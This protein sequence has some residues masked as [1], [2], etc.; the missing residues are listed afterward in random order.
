MIQRLLGRRRLLDLI[1]LLSAG[2]RVLC[3]PHVTLFE[4]GA[5]AG[6]GTAYGRHRPWP[7]PG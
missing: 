2:T 1:W 4:I 5:D 3:A 6:G 7:E